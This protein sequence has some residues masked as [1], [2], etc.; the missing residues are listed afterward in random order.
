M[1]TLPVTGTPHLRNREGHDDFDVT[2]GWSHGTEPGI[3]TVLRV[4]DEAA[5]LPFVLPHLF[6]A[7]DRVIL[8]DN[9]ST[10]GTAEVARQA[11]EQCDAVDRLE[12]RDYPFAVARCGPEH[13][14]TP[15]DSVHSLTYFYNWSFSLVRTGFSLKWDGDM[16]LTPTG[17]SL[18]RDLA[19][20]S[21]VVDMVVKI[22]RY[23][24]YVADERRA[25]LDLGMAN[26]E[27]WG[28]PN[29]PGHHFVK[30]LEWELP[31]WPE[32]I[33]KVTLP[34][35]CCFELKHLDA[36]EFAHWSVDDFTTSPRTARKAR[37][38]HVHRALSA[39]ERLP[40]DLYQIEAPDGVHVID[41][42]REQ[43]LTAN[44]DRLTA[45]SV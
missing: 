40:A 19:W 3:T 18:L 25:F 27:P 11:A 31:M 12:V 41:Y 13:L 14:A 36:D 30:A 28:W 15:P 43:W 33:R 34:Q 39:G 24:L 35:W 16:V 21:E 44:R 26:A 22:P 6:A 23:P 20:Q 42:V 8:V 2:W 7:V 5:S 45:R 32:D 1:T 17:V 10:D 9:G 37:E 4:R 38:W 29:K